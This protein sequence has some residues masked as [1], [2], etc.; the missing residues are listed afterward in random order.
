MYE[1]DETTQQVLRRKEG[2][3]Y[4]ER[5]G[6]VY[7]SSGERYWAFYFEVR[8]EYRQQFVKPADYYVNVVRWAYKELD[9]YTQ[10]LETAARG[11]SNPAL[12]LFTYGTLMAGEPRHSCLS[13]FISSEG[14]PCEMRGKLYSLGNFPILVEHMRS[15]HLVPGEAYHLTTPE[16][17]FSLLDRIEGA[18]AHTE[19]V[20]GYYRTPVL[21][22]TK[23]R[24]RVADAWCYVWWGDLPAGAKRIKEN[25]WRAGKEKLEIPV[26]SMH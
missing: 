10:P 25:Q 15:K 24:G 5:E 11:E 14:T 21:V 13:S 20:A 17:A 16:K 26:L 8:P 7:G 1:V 3:K 2:P 6:W 22:A 19:H 23:A 9:I 4:V 12:P 18:H